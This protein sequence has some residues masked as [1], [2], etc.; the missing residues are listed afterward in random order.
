MRSFALDL[1]GQQWDVQVS[2]NELDALHRPLLQEIA[3]QAAAQAERYVVFLAGPPGSGKTTLGALWEK[4]AHESNLTP[5]ILTLPMDGVHLPNV[6]LDAQTMVRDG[7]A[8]LLRKIKGAPESF[9]L[10]LLKRLLQDVR[11]GQEM[12]WPKYDRQIHDPVA[13]AIAVPRAGILLL[14]GN[15]LLLDEPGWRELKALAD[16]TIFIECA[17]ALSRESLVA[18]GQRGGRS[19]ESAWQHYAFSDLLNWQRVMQHRLASDVVL[20]V[21]D[22]RRLA[23]VL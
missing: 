15:Y 10:P 9:D 5:A 3:R 17:E 2:Q 16:F 20:R 12:A 6:I 18:R 23:R 14:E 21:N 1:A 19:A 11:A 7:Q 4:L 22:Q 8:I 13:N